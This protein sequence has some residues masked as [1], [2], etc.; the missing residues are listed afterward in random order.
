M[1]KLNIKD[2]IDGDLHLRQTNKLNKSSWILVGHKCEFKNIRDF[3]TV[4][5]FDKPIII[6]RFKE[7]LRAFTNVC[8]HRGSIIKDVQRGNGSFTCPYHSWS[9][10]K[11]GLPKSIPLKDKCFKFSNKDLNILKLENWKLEYCG[12]FIFI[13][14]KDIKKTLKVYLNKENFNN[15]QKKSKLIKSHISSY[16]WKWNANW[17]ICVENSIDEYHAIFLHQTSFK[18]TLNLEP[19]Y[20]D[21][22]NVM[23]MKTGMQESYKKSAKNFQK[24]FKKKISSENYEHVLLFPYSALADSMQQSFYIQNYIP[25]KTKETLITSDIYLTE[26]KD[27]YQNLQNMYI[28]SAKK[29]NNTV[30]NE[31]KI[32][33]E[34]IQIGI[35]KREIFEVIGNFE[36]RINTFR[37]KLSEI[38]KK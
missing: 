14:Y 35:A 26:C 28:E 37:K 32:I 30:F 34:N 18:K 17:K 15:L 5:V 31:D 8:S 12:E 4:F 11:D 9:Y 20:Y 7:G 25:L 36:K 22:G 27:D 10:D 1:K 19:K 6:Y 29:F 13:A 3:K 24:I 2:F 38:G 16:R 33:C 23:Y 21:K